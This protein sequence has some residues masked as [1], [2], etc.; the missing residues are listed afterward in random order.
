M[1]V[2]T[3]ARVVFEQPRTGQWLLALERLCQATVA[4]DGQASASLWARPFGGAMRLRDTAPLRARIGVFEFDSERSRAEQDF[5]ILIRPAAWDSLCQYCWQHFSAVDDPV[6]EAG[7]ARELAE[8]FADALAIRLRAEQ[9][10]S[11]PVGIRVAQRPAPTHNPRAPGYPTARIYRVF[12]VRIVDAAL[13]QALLD[14]SEHHSDDDLRAQALADLRQGGR[15]RA[16]AILTVPLKPI[17]EAYLAVSLEARAAPL[18]FDNHSLD[19][20]VPAILDG[21]EMPGYQNLSGV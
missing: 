20:N 6:L 19:V 4:A 12:E 15:G 18:T 1:S 9:V 21:V 3:L 16:T 17:C 2:A 10:V 14:N 8:E 13:A 5:R 11:R 7:P